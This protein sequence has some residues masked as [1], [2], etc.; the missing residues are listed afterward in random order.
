MLVD[1]FGN[2]KMLRLNKLII[3][4]FQKHSN[5]QIDFCDGVNV[6]YGDSET[7]KTCIKHAIEFLCQHDTFK[8]QRKIGT[9][10]TS[11]KGEFS[12]GVVVERIVSTSINRYIL[13]N[14]EKNPFNSVGKNAPDEIKEAIGIY[15]LE[16]DGNSI[17]LNSYTQIGKP[18]LLDLSPSDRAKIFNKLT[19]NDV[20]D[21]LFGQFNKDILR[22]KRNAK[23]ET[24]KFEERSV[25]LKEKQI[26]KE[27]AEVTHSRLKIKVE[28]IKKLYEKYSKLL[29]IKELEEKNISN[30]Q[31]VKYCLKSIKFPEDIVIKELK[32]NIN[33][34]EQLKNLNNA[35]EKVHINLDKVKGQLSDLKP[36]ALNFDALKGKI[37]RF[38]ALEYIKLG[39]DNNKEDCCVVKEDIKN[40]KIGLKDKTIEYKNLLKEAKMLCPKCNE[41]ITEYCLRR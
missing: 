11:V 37:E 17:Y 15:P 8:G 41:D 29:E 40:I 33:K 7:G 3:K 38:E 2:I 28:N 9:K 18:F 22:I 5:L 27:K 13:N 30:L 21:C 34:F 32:E 19:G 24:E 4:N 35:S 6:I 16:I 10:T 25:E 31:E 23:E 36:P 39:F 26:Q 20:L 14:D 1:I 12:N